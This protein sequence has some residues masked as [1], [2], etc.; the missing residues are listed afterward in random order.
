MSKKNRDFTTPEENVIKTDVVDTPNVET[1]AVD[2]VKE[3]PKKEEPVVVNKPV[4]TPTVN[5]KVNAPKPT[6]T[7]SVS[8]GNKVRL[9]DTATTTVTGTKLPAFAY[10]NTYKVT[11][12]LP[13]RVIITANTY[14]IAVKVSDLVLAR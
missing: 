10:K 4:V 11:K 14:T 3:E 5:N 13:S 6:P 12:I 8:V 7:I 1:E 2:T 9:K